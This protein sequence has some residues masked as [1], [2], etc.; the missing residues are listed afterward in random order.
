MEAKTRHHVHW[1]DEEHENSSVQRDQWRGDKKASSLQN[2][3]KKDPT[4]GWKIEEV[5]TEKE[6][7]GF[8]S[9]SLLMYL[10]HV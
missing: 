5:L 8:V 4:N 10:W 1:W 3:A 6:D 9:F 2:N 7:V